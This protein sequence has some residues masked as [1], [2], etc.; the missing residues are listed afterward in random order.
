MAS[1]YVFPQALKE[2]RI[3]FSQTGEASAPI[4]YVK[5]EIRIPKD[6][7]YLKILKKLGFVN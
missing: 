5:T 1:R 3:I 7:I 4:K 2:L 6:A